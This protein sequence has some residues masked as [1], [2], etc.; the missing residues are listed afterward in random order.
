MEILF[1]AGFIIR[2]FGAVANLIT[3]KLHEPLMRMG[4][5]II[6]YGKSVIV[7]CDVRSLEEL[8][9]L[10]EQTCDIYG[11][12]GYKIGSILAIRYGLATIVETI[13]G[14]TDLPII[15]DHQKG[16]TDIPDL[17]EDFVS[18]LKELH[19]NAL[20]GFP[21]SGPLTEERWIRVCE[22]IGLGII[23]GGEMTHP[24]F[25]R[26]EGG[27]ISDK[28]LD[29]IYLLAAKL[30]VNN[31]VVPGT[32]KD[33]ILYYRKLLENVNDLTLY[34]PGLIAQGGVLSEVARVAG[35]RWHAVIGRTIY[36]SL[37]IRA[38]TMEIVNAIISEG[39]IC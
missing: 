20:I 15:Y 25:K 13:R 21:F 36:A 9:R 2:E 35:P 39:G 16:M 11:V 23:I 29:K 27:Y 37:N 4:M 12:G 5:R 31:F 10:V 7:A 1:S 24:K 34:I 8:R 28:A 32:K 6:E 18:M 14:F 33:R 3:I 22:K 30:G 26:S 38:T 19:V 17:A